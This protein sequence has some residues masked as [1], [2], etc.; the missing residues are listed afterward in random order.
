MDRVVLLGLAPPGIDQER[1]LRERVEGD[2]DRQQDTE[3]RQV[4][5][6]QPAQGEQEEVGVFEEG[7]QAQID[8]D[9]DRQQQRAAPPI[10]DTPERYADAVVEGDRQEQ[11]DD[12]PW[13]PP[14]IEEQRSRQQPHGGGAV[15]DAQH[16]PEHGQGERQERED[17]LD[18]VEEHRSIPGHH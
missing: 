12:V 7:Q 9:A 10:G 16:G 18:R 2:A 6:G 3:R 15:P 5:A 13:A 17:E 1:D 14:A 8:R 11:Q 4:D